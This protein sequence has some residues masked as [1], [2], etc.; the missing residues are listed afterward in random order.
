MISLLPD[1]FVFIKK[2]GKTVCYYVNIDGEK[3]WSPYY[4]NAI[5]YDFPDIYK[6][7]DNYRMISTNTVNHLCKMIHSCNFINYSSMVK[8][9]L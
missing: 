9:W 2:D 7:S 3:K 4:V 6:R 5:C 1:K 8:L